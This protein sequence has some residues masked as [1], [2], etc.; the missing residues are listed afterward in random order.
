MKNILFAIIA[1]FAFATPSYAGV[2]C[3]PTHIIHTDLA[4]T[5]NEVVINSIILTDTTILE[6]FASKN[7]LTWSIV[8]VDLSEGIACMVDY[9]GGTAALL[10]AL[11]ILFGPPL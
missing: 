1:L 2:E 8:I 9:G 4:E 7:N 6:V 10:T 3:H 11:D 5:Y